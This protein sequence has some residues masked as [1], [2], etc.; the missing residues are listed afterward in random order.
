MKKS[1]N[2]LYCLIVFTI[3]RW[4]LIIHKT[5][6]KQHENMDIFHLNLGYGNCPPV[7]AHENTLQCAS[8]IRTIEIS[9]Y[10]RFIEKI[11]LKTSP[12][13]KVRFDSINARQRFT[14]LTECFTRKF[15]PPRIHF[16][17]I[18]FALQLIRNR[19]LRISSWA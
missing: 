5:E 15:L 13:F 8:S 3:S 2:R 14:I 17:V 9:S 19:S 1:K 4:T 7:Y 6:G 12:Y 10:A 18:R 11:V 16:R